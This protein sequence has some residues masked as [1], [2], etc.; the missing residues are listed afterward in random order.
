MQ[1]LM[2]NLFLGKDILTNWKIF[3]LDIDGAVAG[4]WPHSGTQTYTDLQN[5]PSAGPAFYSGTLQPNGLAWDTFLKL[6]KWK[7]VVFRFHFL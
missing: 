7:K 3:P 4:G 2:S 6:N 5:E 1:G